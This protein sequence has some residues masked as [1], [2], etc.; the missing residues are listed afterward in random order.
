MKIRKIKAE[1]VLDSRG[2]ST[3]GITVNRKFKGSAP[4]GVSLAK[5]E[6]MPFPER[7]VPIGFVNRALHN[8]L[9]G[10]VVQDFSDLEEV[11]KILF[12]LD[13][14]TNLNKIGGNTVIALEYALLQGMSKNKVWSFLNPSADKFPLPLGC[15]IGGGKHAIESSD[16]QEF[17]LMPY[18]ET[19][20]DN[21]LVSKHIYKQIQQDLHPLRR[22]CTGGWET[23]L[24]NLSVLD[25]LST[26]KDK[27]LSNFGIFV[28]L[29]ID[30]AGSYLFSGGNYLY[31]KGKI[32]RSDQIKYINTLI[33]KYS[34]EYVEDPLDQSDFE[35]F[36]LI[37]GD[38][39]CAD[40][41]VCTNV[42][43]LKNAGRKINCVSIKPTQIGSLLKVKQL[44]DY[45]KANDIST[46]M[47]Y[48]GGETTDTI[49]SDLSV[50]WRSDFIKVGISSIEHAIKLNRLKQIEKEIK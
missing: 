14:S 13:P 9:R 37:K 48:R 5:N 21:V 18:G 42:E 24:D 27:V 15:C 38:L 26:L 23:T 3:I 31:R 43:L 50:A 7:G 47:S 46:V 19:V 2:H 33:N 34:L 20:S 17:L 22:S 4:L 1:I 25:Y 49:M 12:N 35:G 8:G 40:D 6:V 30:V 11:E 29:G 36:G 45:A 10:L 28:G 41:L 16:F 44:V 39:I 32:S